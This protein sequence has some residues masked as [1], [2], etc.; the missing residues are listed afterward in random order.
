MQAVHSRQA[1][2]PRCGRHC[3]PRL[4]SPKARHCR[5]DC[6]SECAARLPAISYCIL[7]RQVNRSAWQSVRTTM[8]A[9][10]HSTPDGKAGAKG[11]TIATRL[12]HNLRQLCNGANMA[13][14]DG[15]LCFA[16]SFRCVP[17]PRTF[18][19]CDPLW[20]CCCSHEAYRPAARPA[21]H[22]N[23][24]H[25]R[26]FTE[27]GRSIPK[28]CSDSPNKQHMMACGRLLL[29]SW[30]LSGP[31]SRQISW[32]RAPC[33]SYRTSAGASRLSFGKGRAS[34]CVCFTYATLAGR[35]TRLTWP[36]L[37]RAPES[38]R[39]SQ[40]LMLRALCGPSY[41]WQWSSCKLACL[42]GTQRCFLLR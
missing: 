39:T 9:S 10:S 6:V 27:S 1:D 7:C 29:G 4:A 2:L 25:A 19:C 28:H 17:E 35:W 42:S 22:R 11:S 16:G 36:S 8:R 5:A 15:T 23:R 21:P 20:H 13:D 3:A 24:R 30:R 37:R 14:L 18:S 12:D 32:I 33:S 38:A 26:S 31:T 40:R 41:F 34:S